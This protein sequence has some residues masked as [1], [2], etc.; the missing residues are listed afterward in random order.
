MPRRQTKIILRQLVSLILLIA[1]VYAA[2]WVYN[3]VANRRYLQRVYVHLEDQYDV[4][5]F[6][7]S[8]IEGIGA[9]QSYGFI[10]RLDDELGVT[11][12]NAGVRRM[13]TDTALPLLEES[14]LSFEPKLVIISLGGNDAIRDIPI[15]Q[16][17]DNFFS[18][19]QSITNTGSHVML[20][21]VHSSLLEEDYGPIYDELKLFFQDDI[22]IVEDF[23]DPVHLKPKYLFDPLHP[24]DEG[25]ALLA[26]E[27]KPELQTLLMKLDIPFGNE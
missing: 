7:D 15:E 24:N 23:Y 1:A 6:G 9:K 27:L 19:I 14:V 17:R 8:L 13:R 26:A 18:I 12:H 4:V 21:G 22:T 5:A 25:H 2:S 3:A 16:T 10:S 11:I 20:L